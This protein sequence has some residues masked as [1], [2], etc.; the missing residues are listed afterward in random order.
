MI[1]VAT[2]KSFMHRVPVDL[3][4]TLRSHKKVSEVWETLTPLTKNEWICWV[5]F[6]KKKETREEHLKRLLEDLLRGKRRPCCWPGCPH[7]R[8]ETLKYFSKKSKV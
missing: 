4:R 7:R 6:F 3:T 2:P 5:T 1:K 8:P